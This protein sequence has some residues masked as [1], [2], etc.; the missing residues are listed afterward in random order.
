[1]SA[2]ASPVKTVTIRDSRGVRRLAVCGEFGG[3]W[4]CRNLDTNRLSYIRPNDLRIVPN[5]TT[6]TVTTGTGEGAEH[7][8]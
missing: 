1:M 4:A 7:C 5:A 2:D 6:G 8:R 3:R